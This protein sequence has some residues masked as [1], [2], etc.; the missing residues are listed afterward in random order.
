MKLIESISEMQSWSKKAKLDGKTIGFVPTMGFLHEGH[1]SL[2][3]TS[4]KENDLTV[5]SIYVNPTQFGPSED[6]NKY[7]RDMENDLEVAE[8]VGVDVVFA[9]SDKQM[10]PDGYQTFVSV[11]KLA[12][13]LEG[14]FRPGHFK[15]VCTI[16]LKFLNLVQPDILYLG[17][18]DAQQCV[19][20][21]RMVKELNLPV[22]VN[23]Q[24]TVREADGLAMSS[25]NTYLNSEERKS[26]TILYS[27]L[28]LAESLI[29]KGK[30]NAE[31]IIKIMQEEIALEK[32]AKIDY[33]A[34]VDPQTLNNMPKIHAPVLICLAVHI[35]KTRLIDNFWLSTL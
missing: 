4:K 23:V 10:Y 32:V 27:S 24:S 15:G 18:K 34:I 11:D 31:E 20:L 33:I 21:S 17:Q 9:P 2:L 35:G 12:E 3:R 26:A 1:A 16:V 19:I 22:S 14:K 7:P 30:V 5:L 8:N 6:F 28:K 25:R 13:K 29:N